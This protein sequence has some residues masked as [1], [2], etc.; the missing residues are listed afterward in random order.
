MLIHCIYTTAVFTAQRS[1]ET[2]KLQHPQGCVTYACSFRVK[3]TKRADTDLGSRSIILLKRCKT[4]V[5][6]PRK[7]ALLL[8]THYHQQS[9]V[10][11]E[12][13]CLNSLR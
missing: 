3:K 6:S 9:T 10:N 13:K 7:I 8:K 5:I 11:S 1:G 2:M 4:F 12:I